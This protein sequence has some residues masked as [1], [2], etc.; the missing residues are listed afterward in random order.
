MAKGVVTSVFSPEAKL[1]RAI[2][3]H[4]TKLGFS[5]AP[6]GSLTIPSTTKEVVR[7]LHSGQ[8]KQKLDASTSFVTQHLTKLISHFA[9]GAELN[10]S[11]IVI[12]QAVRGSGIS[13]R[14]RRIAC[15][16]WTPRRLAVSMTERTSA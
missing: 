9:N 13:A 7:T 10:P 15:R 2:R 12:A 11:K 1:K 4:F 8:R 16:A 14:V 3:R 6:D 5:K